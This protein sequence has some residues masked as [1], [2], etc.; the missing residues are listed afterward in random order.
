MKKLYSIIIPCYNSS[1]TIETALNS[2]PLSNPTIEV[3]V[4]DD[5]SEDNTVSI[6]NKYLI[7]PSFKLICQQNQGAGAA[8]KTG[9]E[10]ATGEFLMFLD[11]DDYYSKDC[12]E[13]LNSVI[14][15]NMDCSLFRFGHR[16]FSVE[17]KA[18]RI[19]N[20][21]QVKKINKEIFL[22][23]VFCREIIMGT[24]GVTLWDKV[25]KRE[26]FIENVHDYGKCVLEDYL[27]N[28]QYYALV[29]S[30][31]EIDAVLYNYR[32]GDISTSRRYHNGTPEV[33]LQITNKKKE[34]MAKLGFDDNDYQNRAIRWLLR[35]C[36]NCLLL[37]LNSGKK[38][39]TREYRKFCKVIK[40]ASENIHLNLLNRIHITFFWNN[41][42]WLCDL[43]S[44]T[45][46]LIRKVKRVVGQSVFYRSNK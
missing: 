4:I 28:M 2:I 6:L 24:V 30:L 32:I 45:R 13:V 8:R 5:G 10:N 27:I 31:V 20:N 21:Y 38:T 29:D 42:F 9:V 11:S 26:I 15:N 37:L 12:F 1:K 41:N 18:H 7:Y 46:G 43:L 35:Y 34:V 17:E 39:K 33:L 19:N 14:M 44:N 22:D 23:K 40:N 3:I 36:H 16:S 25:Y